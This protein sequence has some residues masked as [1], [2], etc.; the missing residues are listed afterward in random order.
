M[1]D[2]R[3]PSEDTGRLPQD[4]LGPHPS[5]DVFATQVE[6]TARTQFGVE[7]LK[8]PGSESA[9]RD[10]AERDPDEEHPPPR[11]R[12]GF[13][14]TMR[15]D[16]V[17]G[18]YRRCHDSALARVLSVVNGKPARGS[19]SALAE[20]MGLS[21]EAVNG[22]WL[23]GRYMGG[24]NWS[25]FVS[26]YYQDLKA[27]QSPT[28][29]E[30]ALAGYRLATLRA[31][32]LLK[33]AGKRVD[34]RSHERDTGNSNG[35]KQES[36]DA[37]PPHWFDQVAPMTAALGTKNDGPTDPI[38]RREFTPVLDMQFEILYW[39]LR[40]P[41]PERVTAKTVV[42][43]G[44][45]EGAALFRFCKKRYESAL[46]AEGINTSDDLLHYAEVLVKTYF[47]GFLVAV[48]AIRIAWHLEDPSSV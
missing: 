13:V 20:S 38:L 5:A 40:L 44:R 30:R 23:R 9:N 34:A 11:G 37:H 28:R 15:D 31:N 1:G 46:T 35:P 42:R 7:S 6:R 39:A 18:R 16:F 12:S 27:L 43:F 33:A 22:W 24:E 47:P 3:S 10:D 45:D 29:R 26:L 36:V 32:R 17:L 48:L 21:R 8:P 41:L 2:Q 25:L 14:A 19:R 4:G